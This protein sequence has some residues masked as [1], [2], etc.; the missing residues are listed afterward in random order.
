MRLIEEY[1]VREK[2]SINS[3]IRKQKGERSEVYSISS[4]SRGNDD[5]GG[6][7]DGDDGDDGDDGGDDSVSCVM[8]NVRVY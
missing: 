7:G 2:Y 8:L 4:K 1:K 5:C 3:K 6:G